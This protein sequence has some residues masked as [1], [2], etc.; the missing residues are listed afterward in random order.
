MVELMI[1]A[2]W[3]TYI[4]T[5]NIKYLKWFLPSYFNKVQILG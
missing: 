1:T 2:Q 3:S 4:Q 5:D